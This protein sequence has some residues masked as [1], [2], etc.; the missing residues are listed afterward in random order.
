MCIVL[1]VRK[2]PSETVNLA[3]HKFTDAHDK[4]WR[5]PLICCRQSNTAVI[6]LRL[7]A[8]TLSG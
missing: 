2:L 7:I 6:T 1:R 4:T 8:K 5:V 3:D